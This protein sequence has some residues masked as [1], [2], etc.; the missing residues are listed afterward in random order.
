MHLITL[1]ILSVT[2]ISAIDRRNSLRRE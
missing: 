2:G 1:D